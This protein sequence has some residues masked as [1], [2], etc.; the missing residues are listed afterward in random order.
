MKYVFPEID[1]TFDTEC[2]I[3]NTI[4]IENQRLFC[5]LIEDMRSQLSGNDGRAVLSRGDKILSIGKSVELLDSFIPLDINTK[6]LVSRLSA[7]LESRAISDEFYAEMS[8]LVG[9]TEAFL[10]ALAFELP[11]EIQFTKMNI[12]SIIKAAGVEICDDAQSLAERVLDY[13]QLVTEL[14]GEKLF[15]TVNLRSYVSDEE[16]ELLMQTVLSHGYH[17]LMIENCEHER[18]AHEKR[19]IMDKDLCLIL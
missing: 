9:R 7:Q 16:T 11:C 8:E 1:F 2:D 19:T 10:D 13:M 18:L 17:L 6:A 5:T 4:V 14:I 12:G 15:V 3:I